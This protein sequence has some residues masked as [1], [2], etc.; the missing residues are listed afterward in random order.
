MNWEV[1][2]RKQVF[3]NLSTITVCVEEGKRT[4]QLS[5]KSAVLWTETSNKGLPN[6]KEPLP[7]EP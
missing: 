4:T 2:E 5:V 7:T 6:K 1:C 3:S